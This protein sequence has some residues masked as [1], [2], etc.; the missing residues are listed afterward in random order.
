MFSVWVRTWRKH[1]VAQRQQRSCARKDLGMLKVYPREGE[2]QRSASATTPE[3]SHK[4]VL[5][6]GEV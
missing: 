4:A 3:G 1:K 2:N 5:K 6:A